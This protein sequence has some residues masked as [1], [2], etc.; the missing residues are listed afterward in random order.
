MAKIIP[1]NANLGTKVELTIE[2]AISNGLSDFL[3][4]LHDWVFG[5]VQQVIDTVAIALMNGQRGLFEQFLADP[6]FPNQGK[7]IINAMLRGNNA[8]TIFGNLTLVWGIINAWQQSKILP[9]LN[10]G[11][12][13]ANKDFPTV[14]LSPE[15]YIRAGLTAYSDPRKF[16]DEL[17]RTG[18]KGEDITRAIISLRPLLS[19]ADLANASVQNQMTDTEIESYRARL[20]IDTADMQTLIKLAGEPPGIDTLLEGWNRGFI[21]ESFVEQGLKESRLKNKYNDFIK[22]LRFK[23]P[24]ISDLIRFM[25]REAFDDNISQKFSYDNDYPSQIDSFVEQNGLSRDWAKRYWRAHW[26]L[27]S[28]SQAYD[29]L[30]RNLITIDDLASLLKTA[31]YPRFWREKLIQLSTEL[32]TRVDVRRMFRI[33]VLDESGVLKSYKELGYNDERASKLTE[34][35]VKDVRLE[36]KDL[37]KNELL[38]LF[39]DSIIDETYLTNSLIKLG[40]DSVEIQYLISASQLKKQKSITNDEIKAIQTKFIDGNIDNSSALSLLAKAGLDNLAG[41]A[42]VDLWTA[43]KAGKVAKPTTAKL[44]SWYE[45]DIITLDDFESE[46][47]KLGW[48]E[49]Y[50]SY[51]SKAESEA[52]SKLQQAQLQK[53]IDARIKLETSAIKS[54]YRLAVADINI[55]IAELKASIAD[56]QL[57]IKLSTDIDEQDKLKSQ[58][59]EQKNAIAHLQVDKAKLVPDVIR[60]GG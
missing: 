10:Q 31:D 13:I 43:T 5:I 46:L 34:F 3:L 59:D 53:E 39:E 32:Y 22:Q 30:H 4:A 55:Q 28:P 44:E 7:N 12:Q 21:D 27:P 56:A 47:V 49:P 20:D 18:L 15:Q 50:I 42:K 48:F 57:G 45:D 9:S 54:S 33:G 11:N 36:Q 26:Q 52:K 58:I 51:Y 16:L 29:M 25:V 1:P 41:Q 60:G 2:N 40:Y 6:D 14:L 17:T 8:Q 19:G 37:T 24:P 38:G 35:T 23:I